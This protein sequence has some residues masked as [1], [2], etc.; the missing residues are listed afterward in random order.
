M[1]SYKWVFAALTGFSALVQTA[2]FSAGDLS[3]SKDAITL[4]G[5]FNYAV[6]GYD[7]R[8]HHAR[9]PFAV[10]SGNG[11]TYVAY[12]SGNTVYVQQVDHANGFAAVGSPAA[13]SGLVAGGLVAHDD[14]FALLTTRKDGTTANG[15]PTAYLV[16]YQN[17]KETWAT[18]LVCVSVL[19]DES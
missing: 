6:P 5:G 13:V 15:E 19:F 9:T 18:P 8:P 7:Y 2:A 4:A 11:N 12:L 17:G 3:V 14:G 1:L 16:R 10:S